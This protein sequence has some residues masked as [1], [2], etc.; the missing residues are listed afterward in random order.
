M[1]GYTVGDWG[2]NPQ[3]V[4]CPSDRPTVSN[5]W[6]SH[7]IQI[8]PEKPRRQNDCCSPDELKRAIEAA[9]KN[10]KLPAPP[11]APAVPTAPVRSDA[12]IAAALAPLLMPLLGLPVV[13]PEPNTFELRDAFG[14][15][16]MS[17]GD[18][19]SDRYTPYT[20]P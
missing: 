20:R 15:V 19:I 8:E 16:I 17:K 14:K 1:S 6:G 7:T 10:I 13:F 11:V 3:P 2:C 4:A 18:V 12:E 9:L 5:A